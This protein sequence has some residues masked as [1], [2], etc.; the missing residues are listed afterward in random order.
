MILSRREELESEYFESRARLGRWKPSAIMHSICLQ[1]ELNRRR[2]SLLFREGSTLP[3]QEF[4]GC[5]QAT[6]LMASHFTCLLTLIFIS[7]GLRP[8]N[9]K[10]SVNF[11]VDLCLQ[12]VYDAVGSPA[13]PAEDTRGYQKVAYLRLYQ[14]DWRADGRISGR[15][16]RG[17]S[18]VPSAKPS[19]RAGRP[20]PLSPAKTCD[21]AISQKLP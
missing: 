10:Y 2:M 1:L 16:W 20:I 7:A 15:Y 19:S 9:L 11:D 12:P 8:A 17:R 4:A 5:V 6:L 21:F 3:L 18:G 14:I 13:S